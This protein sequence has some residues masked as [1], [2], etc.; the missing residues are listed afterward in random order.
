MANKKKK[1]T[2]Q[3]VQFNERLDFY[4]RWEKQFLDLE[5]RIQ[6]V[7]FDGKDELDEATSDRI[8]EDVMLSLVEHLRM[9]RGAPEKKILQAWAKAA[10]A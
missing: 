4:Q 8:F 3:D 1:L 10:S 7:E 6:Y 5:E 2:K 9:K